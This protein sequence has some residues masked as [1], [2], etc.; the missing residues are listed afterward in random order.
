VFL[1]TGEYIGMLVRGAGETFNLIVP[2]RRIQKWAKSEDIEWALDPSV[3][4]P[5]LQE[6]NKLP[7]EKIGKL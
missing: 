1:T 7:K 3:K 2:M 6:I 4:A 5:T